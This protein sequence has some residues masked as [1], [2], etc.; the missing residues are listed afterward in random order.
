MSKS[1]TD[2]EQILGEG[3]TLPRVQ[4]WLE[5]GTKLISLFLKRLKKEKERN[6]S[7]RNILGEGRSLRPR[8]SVLGLNCS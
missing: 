7:A 4:M 6:K 2:Q 3:A 1:L 5:V 8:G